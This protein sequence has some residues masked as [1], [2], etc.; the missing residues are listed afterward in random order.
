MTGLRV[1]G[2]EIPEATIAFEAQNHPAKSAAGA[3]E[4]ACKALVVRELLLQEAGRR[5]LSPQPRRQGAIEETEDESLIR[6][7]LEQAVVV[8]EPSDEE[9]HTLYEAQPLRFISPDLFE[10]SH[11]LLAA[12]VDDQEKRDLAD[13]LARAMWDD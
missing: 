5:G 7:L 4:A 1:N 2:R 9:C 3:V 12:A 8:E 10:A 6:Q 11:I 13:A